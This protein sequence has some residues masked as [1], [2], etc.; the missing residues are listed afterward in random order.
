MNAKN[1]WI[2]LG[3]LGAFLLWIG[4]T[5]F[6]PKKVFKKEEGRKPGAT[7]IEPVFTHEGNLLLLRGDSTLAE[8]MIEIAA[9]PNELQ[10]GMMYRKRVPENTGMLFLMPYEEMQSFWMRNTYVSLDIIYLDAAGKVVSIQKNA[11]PL[12]EQSLPSEG[13]ALYVLEVAGGYTDQIGLR[14][15]DRFEARDLDNQRVAPQES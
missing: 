8:L 6:V 9:T 15:G 13:P 4:L 12:N 5:V 7:M 2:A 10:Y 14:K 3:L 11:R 1:R